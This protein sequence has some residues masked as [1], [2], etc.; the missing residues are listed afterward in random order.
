MSRVSNLN[1]HKAQKVG[2]F[3]HL[4]CSQ[5]CAGS[6]KVMVQQTWNLSDGFYW[7]SCLNFEIHSSWVA[8]II[9]MKCSSILDSWLF[10]PNKN[11]FFTCMAR[12][13]SDKFHVWLKG[14]EEMFSIIR[15]VFKPY[16][17]SHFWNL[18]TIFQSLLYHWILTTS[19][20]KVGR[21]LRLKNEQC[22]PCTHC[23]TK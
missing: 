21:A 19:Q 4:V 3:K 17:P 6:W 18:D 10:Y 22:M 16:N 8:N 20:T 15:L 2:S 9:H 14:Y 12:G 5:E 7:Q 1:G 13:A 11:R 23:L